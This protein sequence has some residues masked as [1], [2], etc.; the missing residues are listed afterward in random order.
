MERD[1]AGWRVFE[2]L[3]PYINNYIDA[4]SP[5]PLPTLRDVGKAVGVSGSRVG[6]IVS[7]AGIDWRLLHSKHPRTKNTTVCPKC[8]GRKSAQ[9]KVCRK[10]YAPVWQLICQQCHNVFARSASRQRR[11]RKSQRKEAGTFCSV[12]CAQKSRWSKEDVR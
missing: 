4:E 10:C 11:Y 8:W 6:Q 5:G 9:A 7:S 3:E 12:R 2:L 1:T